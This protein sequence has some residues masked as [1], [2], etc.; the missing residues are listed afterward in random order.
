[1]PSEKNVKLIKNEKGQNKRLKEY[2]EVKENHI[3]NEDEEEKDIVSEKLKNNLLNN[4]QGD[5]NDVAKLLQNLE[6]DSNDECLICI[7]RLKGR[8]Q[9]FSCDGC[10]YSFHLLC[11][12]KWA[13]DSMNQKKL[14]YENQPAGYYDNQGIFIKKKALNIF[15][16]CPACR[17]KYESDQIPRNYYCY[18]KKERDPEFQEW[19]FPHSCGQICGKQLESNCHHTC[20]L[21][22]H[23]GKCPP[24]PQTIQTS[25]KC[26]KSPL[27]TI[28]C[29]QKSWSC[30]KKCS[31]KLLCGIHECSEICCEN[32]PPCKKK[33]Q[34]KCFCQ[35]LSKEINCEQKSWSCGKVC[36]KKLSCSN[37]TCERICHDDDC[38]NCP[39]GIS[40]NCYCGKQTFSVSNCDQSSLNLCCGDTCLKVLECSHQCMLRCHKGDCNSCMIEVEKRCRCG[41]FTKKFPCSKELLCE[42]KCNKMKSC[43]KHNC[44]ARCCVECSPCNIICGKT[45][46]C[47][48]HK[49]EAFC[50]GSLSCYPCTERQK[51]SCRCG[52]TSIEVRCSKG[53]KNRVV[54]CKE[55]CRLPT[56][57]HHNSTPHSCHFGNCENCRQICNEVLE[58]KH[59]CK[60]ICHDFVKVVVKD[61][62]FVPA[63]PWEKAGERIE[64]KKLPHSACKTKIPI[65]CLG[66]HETVMM[67]CHEAK[68]TSCGR[69]CNR[70]L[71]CGNHTC[72]KQCHKVVDLNSQIQDENCD[73]CTSPCIKERP[74]GCTHPCTRPCHELSKPCKKC[75]VQIKT[76]C[77]CGLTDVLYRCCDVYKRDIDNNTRNALKEKLLCCGSR[78]IKLYQKCGHQCVANCHPGECNQQDCRKKV[79]L[80][81]VCKNRKVEYSCDKIRIDNIIVADCDETCEEKKRLLEAE[82]KKAIEMQLKMEEEKNRRELEEYQ[83][84]FGPKKFKE[85][86]RRTVEEEK[87]NKSL[88]LI[89]SLSIIICIVSAILYHFLLK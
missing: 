83:K 46:S 29:S 22:C 86:K 53:S 24:C 52:S 9:I 51:I 68:V 41:A 73:D 78:C 28:R 64:F 80:P 56:N 69:I 20:T 71:V 15:W 49:C 23:P 79:K 26:K 21:F 65:T 25:C 34:K 6:G 36:G 37:H 10:F 55:L 45:L 35:R 47:G 13:N 33:S 88:I 61:K 59:L 7:G 74:Q 8:D 44:K 43:K 3:D 2:E 32:C 62:N 50:H 58:C 66:G 30:T 19:I 39:Y 12:Q 42:T 27:K 40:R 1:M 38:G 18:C 70:K 89:I 5:V 75:I 76:K 63:G 60:D 54:K 81:C 84:K 11:I 48:K 57:C 77:F 72:Q 17:K 14:F 87:S 67:N 85:R 82:N 4:Y 16:D 31:K